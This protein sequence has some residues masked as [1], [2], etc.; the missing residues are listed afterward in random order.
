[1][2]RR[3]KQAH[4]GSAVPF[5]LKTP[6]FIVIVSVLI[7]SLATGLRAGGEGLSNTFST[8]VR[9][10]MITL[11]DDIPGLRAAS[12]Q[13]AAFP[14]HLSREIGADLESLAAD[15]SADARRVRLWIEQKQAEQN[16]P[17]SCAEADGVC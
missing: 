4:I 11:R 17:S 6:F 13:A 16:G 9:A 12:R 1:L 7:G 14:G 15:V 2:Y 8:E 5:L 3:D 10:G